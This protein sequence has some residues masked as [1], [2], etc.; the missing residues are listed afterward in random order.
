MRAKEQVLV[1]RCIE[2]QREEILKLRRLLPSRICA[3]PALQRRGSPHRRKALNKQNSEGRLR[4]E[5]NPF[6]LSFVVIALA[7]F[8]ERSSPKEK[9]LSKK[10]RACPWVTH[11]HCENFLKKVLS[12]T[13]FTCLPGATCSR[14]RL[15]YHSHRGWQSSYTG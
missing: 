7:F 14:T 5:A 6:I 3:T 10:E 11:P 12:K 2:L 9:R 15:P 1:K 8:F 13:S 4:T